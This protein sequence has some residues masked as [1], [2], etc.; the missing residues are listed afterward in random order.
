MVS[1]KVIGLDLT[2]RDGF[3]K[4]LTGRVGDKG[5]KYL[6]RL[7]N[8]GVLFDLSQAEQIALLG[9]TPSGYYVDAVGFPQDDGTIQVEL[10]SAFN[11]ELG[12]FQRCFIRV[13][14]KT[15]ETLSTQDMIY[16]SYG[17]ADISAGGGKDYIGRVE[18]LID[19]LNEMVDNFKGDLE[20]KYNEVL[21]DLNEATSKLA[22]LENRMKALED[23]GAITKDEADTFYMKQLS[24]AL[25]ADDWNT[26]QEV[27]TYGI[28][29]GTGANA[30]VNTSGTLLVQAYGTG[31]T[32]RTQVFINSN[33]IRY[34]QYQGGGNWTTWQTLSNLGNT[35]G[36]YMNIVSTDIVAQDWNTLQTIGT[37]NVNGA[38]GENR[39]S[40]SDIYGTLLVQGKAHNGS[41]LTQMFIGNT[42]LLVRRKTGA[43][44]WNAWHSLTPAIATGTEVSAGTDNTKFLTPKS[45]ADSNIAT[46]DDVNAS[47]SNAIETML[48]N[49]GGKQIVWGENRQV[50]DPPNPNF[51]KF[52]VSDNHK[53]TNL[54][55]WGKYFTVDANGLITV[56][57]AGLFVISAVAKRQF[58][59][60]ITAWHYI[61]LVQTKASDKKEVTHDF[62]PY[63][64]TMQNRNR[65]VVQVTAPFAVGDTIHFKS[66]SS[67]TTDNALQFINV[68]QFCMERLGDGE[69]TV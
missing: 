19:E 2:K 33:S 44:T 56:K 50:T 48:T 54:N 3:N 57:K 4:A 45:V 1:P 39:P 42:T 40:T 55:S 16:Y 21:A 8:N 9:L 12:Y 37:Y 17:N 68:D 28:T 46:T 59:K 10:P 27:G 13:V 63:G 35:D 22:D 52:Y 51:G 67:Y 5:E 20:T 26:Y 30:P 25:G 69:I 66:E 23:G 47:I 60:S 64:G 38:T 36:K 34:R 7:F 11:A 53:G 61:S 43:T 65:W 31:G 62:S 14:L 24:N 29:T 15:G 18:E 41:T 6:F 49:R 58:R 32:G